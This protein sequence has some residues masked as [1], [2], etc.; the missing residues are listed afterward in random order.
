MRYIFD[1]NMLMSGIEVEKLDFDKAYL[2]I[3][4]IEELDNHNH[5]GTGEKAFKSRR[6]MKLIKKLDEQG[7]IEFV[8]LPE[9]VLKEISSLDTIKND[10]IILKTAFYIQSF[11][12]EAILA[13][14]D[15]NMYLKAKPLDIVCELMS[16]T[17]EDVY[18]GYIEVKGN[19]DY[20][21]KFFEEFDMSTL[22]VNEYVLFYNT[23]DDSEWENR[24]DGSKLIP[25]KLPASKVVKAKNQLQRCALD[26]LNN[27]SITTV[28][29]LGGYGSGKTYLCTQMAT[30]F[31]LDKK[32]QKKILGIR[33]PQGEG[34]D[35]GYLK[36]TFEDKTAMFFKP[37][38]Q[39]IASEGCDYLISSKILE[40]TIPYYMKGTTYED[41]IM[42]I[43]EAE[44][45]TEEQIRLIGTRTG[46]NSRL[47]FAGDFA[48]SVNNKT[49]GNPM[50]KMCE[51]LKGEKMFGCIYLDEDVRSSTSKMFANLFK[52]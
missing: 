12:H 52:K 11:D 43:D 4:V 21:N 20:I 15:L 9:N 36:G 29:I 23:D 27:K 18:K 3:T 33:E 26:L 1:T 13:T 5:L 34:K 2:P 40:T 44:D 31:V 41:T 22:H 24:W 51:E 45:L 10:N 38:E 49:F 42:L 35:V 6:A 25:L 17:D 7:K 14:K 47:F 50:V 30:Y 19:T 37:L 46:E 32:D 28:A 8:S 39:Q 16:I 48:Q